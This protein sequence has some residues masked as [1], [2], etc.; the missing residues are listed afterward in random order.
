MEERT[1]EEE[2]YLLGTHEAEIA[3]LGF[4]H[5]VWRAEATQGWERA[6]FR[7]GHRLLDIG[8][9][10]GHTTFDMATLVGDSGEVVGV[11]L[12]PRF[13][14]HVNAQAVARGVHNVSALAQNVERL[15]IGEKSFDGAYTRW[16]LCFV[17]DPEAVVAGVAKAL[18]PGAPFVVQ[19]YLN[20]T[21]ITFAPPS[22]AF[23][24]GIAAT[25][26]SWRDRGGDPNVGAHLA[27]IMARCG[28]EATSVTPI[29]RIA[30][31]GSALWQWPETFFRGYLPNLV[32]WGLLAAEEAAAFL[33]EWERRAED[34]G[35]FLLTPPMVEVIGTKR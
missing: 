33:E 32:E 19:D 7:R 34:P 27:A 21:G 30:R 26:R 14:A 3:R 18:K 25:V 23:S 16:V 8:C 10:P 2:E 9:G 12:S 11:D 22:E 28:L 20:Y 15:E 35:A 6:G 29:V 24:R 1:N 31:P 17:E 4:Q 13:I 5:Q